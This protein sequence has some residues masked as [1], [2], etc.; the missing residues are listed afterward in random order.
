MQFKKGFKIKPKYIASTGDVIFTDG[1]NDVIPNQLSCE[2]YGYVYNE[3]TGT[4]TAFKYNT[5]INNT[6]DNVHNIVKGNLNTTNKGTENSF[7]LGANNTSSGNNLN[8]LVSGKNNLVDNGLNDSSIIGGS[9]AQSKNQGEVVIGGGGFNEELAMSQMSFIQ[10][11]GNTTDGTETALLTQY[12][13]LTYI[14]K[15]KNSV[16]GFEAHVVGVNTGIGDG[17]AGDYGYFKITGGVKFTNGLA[18]YYHVDVHAVVPHG[19]SV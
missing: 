3:T 14:Q 8:I 1:T 16:I 18:S 6:S 2:S 19:H 4:C 12:L 10:Q 9:F 15:V 13:P 7:L 11:S 5:K 17:S